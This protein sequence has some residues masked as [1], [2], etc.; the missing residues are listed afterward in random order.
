MPKCLICEEIYDNDVFS[1]GKQYQS[2][3]LKS[4]DYDNLSKFPLT[5]AECPKC[6]L[7]QLTE[8]LPPDSMYR[9]YFY[10][11]SKNQSMVESLRDVYNSVLTYVPEPKACIDGGCNDGTLLAFYDK[12]VFR[13]GFDPG[14]SL[15]GHLNEDIV[16]LFVNNYFSSAIDFK[17]KFDVITTI[18]MFYDVPNPHQFIEDVKVYLERNGIWVI[19]FTDLYSMIS[20][21]AFDNITFEHLA[22]YSLEVLKQLVESHGM[23]IFSV[24]SNNV[25]GGSLRAFVGW[26]DVRPIEK[27]VQEYLDM[28]KNEIGEDWNELLFNKVSS[29]KGSVVNFIR[30]AAHDGLS[31]FGLGASTKGNCL[32]QYFGLNRDD[33]SYL[34][35]VS[36]FKFGKVSVGSDIPII[37]EEAGLALHPDFLLVLPWHFI[38][39]LKHRLKPYLDAGG[40]LIAPMPEPRLITKNGETLL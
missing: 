36:E 11:S 29:I 1:L 17:R 13:V 40:T 18:A 23:E 5:L 27:Y 19:Q 7:V 9:E 3:F 33:I 34:L 31:T 37:E 32:L 6:K 2:L 4:P 15:K 25:N 12:E 24:S 14:N 20:T 28:E 22:Y 30:K 26:K 21:V 16:D 35:E 10:R 38:D 39:N 8:E